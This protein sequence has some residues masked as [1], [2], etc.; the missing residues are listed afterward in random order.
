MNEIRTNNPAFGHPGIEPRWTHGSKEGVGTAYSTASKIWYTLW[1]G[2]ITEIF[3]PTI[4]K[5]QTRDTQYLV[6]DGKSWFKS[7]KQHLKTEIEQIDCHSLGYRIVNR[8]P[9]GKFKITKE[10][11]SDPHLSCIL[12]RTVFESDTDLHLYLISAPHLEI[13]GKGNNGYAI[14]IAGYKILVAQKQETWMAIAA[15]IPFKK[16]SCGYVGQSDGWQ[17]LADN[18]VMDWEFDRAEDG[19]IAL[20]SELDL[21]CGNEFTLGIAF[22]NTLH[23]AITTLLQGLDIPYDRQKENFITQWQRTCNKLCPLDRISSDDGNLYHSSFSLILAHEDKS[24][25]GALIASLSIPWGQVKTDDADYGGYHL[26]WPRDLYNSATAL[27]AAGY[28]ET[29]LRTLI[30]LATCQQEDGGFAQNFWID[31]T[32]DRQSAQLDE[33]A[34]PILLAWSL[35]K[36]SALRHFDPY[37]MAIE[38][39]KY[40]ILHSPV[41]PQERWEQS[42]GFSPATLATVIAA[43]T[44]T[45]VWTESKGD[46]D[47]ARFIQAYADFLECHIETWTVTTRGTLV[48]DI[49]RHYIRITP[50]DPEDIQPNEDPNSGTITVPHR[51]PDSP[52]EFPAKEIVD[53]SFLQLVRYGVRSPNDPLIIDSLKV[54]DAVL[55]TETPHG[56]VWKRYNHDGHGQ[57]EDGSAWD[58]WGTGRSWVLLTGERGQYELAAGGDPRPYI[59]ALE[60]FAT[61]TGLLPEQVWDAEDI[62]N[63]HMYLG[64]PTGSAMPLLWSHSEY[65]KLLRSTMDGQPYDYLPE[66]GDRYLADRSQ[67]QL[68][69]IWQL[70]RQVARVKTGYTLRIQIPKSFSLQWTND[71][72]QTKRTV[73][74]INTRLGISYVDLEIKEEMRSGA[75]HSLRSPICFKLNQEKQIYRVDIIS[76]S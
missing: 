24:Y 10:I 41:T 25:P 5:P 9:E 30:Y 67:C 68:L 49:P 23:K 22:G 14:D 64:R 54:V 63:A 28:D 70:N 35:K 38:A 76:S 7:E 66:V 40:L 12:Q 52:S 55:K 20:M 72:W 3:F 1:N 17:D 37:P 21:D 18:Y 59:E 73:E 36:E 26:V 56:P 65:I 74:S 58:K 62:P 6:S 15:T 46:R 33:V 42:S 51:H 75:A 53:P 47:T 27:L 44:C 60:G 13:G 34:Y 16:L 29:P 11:I 8:D 43:L 61:P 31:G 69:E 32:P 50:A 2:V 45:A 39:A 4:D 48:P 19:N 57:R 71:D